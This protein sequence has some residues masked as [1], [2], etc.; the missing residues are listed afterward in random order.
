MYWGSS[1]GCAP[2]PVTSRSLQGQAPPSAPQLSGLTAHSIGAAQLQRYLPPVV[3]FCVWNGWNGFFLFSYPEQCLQGNCDLQEKQLGFS[4]TPLG[5]GC[6]S[7]RAGRGPLRH[8]WGGLLTAL[9]SLTNT[10]EVIHTSKAINWVL[11]LL[12]LWVME[13]LP[14]KMAFSCQVNNTILF[15]N[16]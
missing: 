8:A 16:V 3:C 10:A 2:G 7:S 11:P 15:L 1:A 4:L 9:L 14:S 5:G 12:V 13:P 6:R